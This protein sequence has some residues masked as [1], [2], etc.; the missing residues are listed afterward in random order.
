MHAKCQALCKRTTKA[1]PSKFTVSHYRRLEKGDMAVFAAH[2]PAVCYSPRIDGCIYLQRVGPH[3]GGARAGRIPFTP[4]ILPLKTPRAFRAGADAAPVSSTIHW[5]WQSCS[6]TGNRPTRS[7]C[8]HTTG[9]N[10]WYKLAQVKQAQVEAA[11]EIRVATA[12]DA[13]ALA[14]IALQCG[15]DWDVPALQVTMHF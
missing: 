12:Q 4:A 7:A 2:S 3:R 15:L 13:A 8:C 6:S 11:A 14:A 9:T 1:L 5:R 10:P